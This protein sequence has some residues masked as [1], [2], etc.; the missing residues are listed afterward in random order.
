MKVCPVDFLAFKFILKND[1]HKK[2]SYEN[3]VFFSQQSVVE[4][5]STVRR[6]ANHAPAATVF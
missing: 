6:D 4:V 5:E 2:P 3:T 1:N